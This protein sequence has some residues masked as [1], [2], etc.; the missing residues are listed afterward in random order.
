MLIPVYVTRILDRDGR[1]IGT[2]IIDT[3]HDVALIRGDKP[4][5]TTY[6]AKKYLEDKGY[7]VFTGLIGDFFELQDKL[8]LSSD[9]ERQE[10]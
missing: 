3:A 1:D 8:F 9:L 6:F 2:N 4:F 7:I 5:A 10:E